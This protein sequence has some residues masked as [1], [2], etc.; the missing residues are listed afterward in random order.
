MPTDWT[1]E[2]TPSQAAVRL[3]QYGYFNDGVIGAEQEAV[4]ITEWETSDL[5]Q[6]IE[7]FQDVY[8]ETLERMAK[9]EGKMFESDGRNDPYTEALLLAPRCGFPDTAE[10]VR[11]RYGI[12]P[13]EARWPDPCKDKLTFARLFELINNS[14]DV[15]QT[16]R[17]YLDA[18]SAWSEELELM[19][20]INNSLGKGASIWAGKGSLSGGVLAWSYLAQNSCQVHLE[21]RY[22]TRVD[23]NQRYLQAVS[24]HELGHAIGLGHLNT[25]AALM[26]PYARQS[27]YE[28]QAPDIAACLQLGYKKRTGTPPDPPDPEPPLG[29][30]VVRIETIH[31]SGRRSQFVPASSDGGSGTEW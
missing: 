14:L 10:A 25:E 20:T 12:E 22:N 13:M 8:F 27:V 26:Y 19:I 6:S 16:N 18:T 4:H 28:P 2:L 5:E 3:W 1:P 29:D 9:A 24:C 21:Q 30:P 11:S 15:E 17:A 31:K 23:W 7:W